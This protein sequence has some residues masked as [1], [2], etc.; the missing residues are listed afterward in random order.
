METCGCSIYSAA[1]YTSSIVS[2]T[3]ILH[4]LTTGKN[5]QNR[6]AD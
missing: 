2:G 3:Y 1:R 5:S 4:V 6:Q